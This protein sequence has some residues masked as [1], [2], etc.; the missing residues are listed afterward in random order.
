MAQ[1]RYYTRAEANA[2]RPWVGQR[3]HRMRD[4]AGRLRTPPCRAALARLDASAGGGWA[5]H[6][7]ARAAIELVV[8]AAE[9]EA[10]DVVVRDPIGGLVDFPSLRDGGEVYLCWRVDEEEVAF[11]H[12]PEAGFAGRRRL[13]D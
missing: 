11:W 4:A 5:G 13:E 3:V 10:V 1:R 12:E 8:A 9:L 7:A 2:A 6:A